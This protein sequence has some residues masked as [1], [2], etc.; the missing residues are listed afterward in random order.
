[1]APLQHRSRL[2][3]GRAL[4]GVGFLILWSLLGCGGGGSGDQ[5][6]IEARETA[7]S[8]VR[9]AL[10]LTGQTSGTQSLLQAVSPVNARVVWVSGHDGTYGRTTDGGTTWRSAVMEGEET[11][12]FRDVEAFDSLTAFLMSAGP[13]ALSRIYR[14][15]DG[16]GVWRLQYQADRPET[17]LDC[18][19][20]WDRER[21]L[22]YGDAVDGEPFILRTVDG[23]ES[24]NRV[25]A[26]G[27]P[28]ALDGEGGFAASGTCVM[29]GSDG[30]A[31]IATGAG[32]RARVLLTE[33]WGNHWTA[34][35]VPVV[36]GESS[37]LTTLAVGP[38]GWGVAM[39]GIIGGDT[40]RTENLAV[41][42]DG[43]GRWHPGPAPVMRGPIY[44]SALLEL[45]GDSGV[46]A[47]G[48]G[49]LDWAMGP[50]L[51]WQSAD[52][53][54]YWAVAFSGAGAGWA[55]GPQGRIT[56]LSFAV[57]G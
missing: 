35:D 31:W 41:T 25:P 47:V 44:G 4:R 53:R 2:F 55:V 37:G 33:D 43:G 38:G 30:D 6:E 34:V 8:R 29:T 39:G 20:F 23:G 22:A 16:G 1:M 45:G 21:G 48:P 10:T 42:R 50:G 13:G 56:R 46:V 36:A 9:W 57:E 3:S 52:S 5:E 12:Q 11:L 51:A 32:P 14:T 26:S 49:G 54:P 18:M 17:F 15:D 19:A 24:W 27:L 7:Q 28:P 40:L